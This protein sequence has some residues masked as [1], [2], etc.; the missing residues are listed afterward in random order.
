MAE[1]NLTGLKIKDSYEGL[2]HLNDNGLSTNSGEAAAKKVYD[3]VGKSTCLDIAKDYL[4]I[5]GDGKFESALGDPILT[6]NSAQGGVGIGTDGLVASAALDVRG[7]Y[8]ALDSNNSGVRGWITQGGDAQGIGLAGGGNAG[9]AVADLYVN[10]VGKVGIG[11]ETPGSMLE[12]KGDGVNSFGGI[13]ID[14]VGDGNYGFIDQGVNGT[15]IGLRGASPQDGTQVCE[16]YAK[17]GKVG[18]GTETPQKQLHIVGEM[19]Y[20]HGTPEVGQVLTCTSTTG[21]VA[22]RAPAAGVTASSRF[23]ISTG[24]SPTAII[25]N[26][27][28]FSSIVRIGLGRYRLTFSTPRVS[29]SSYTVVATRE[30]PDANFNG[31]AFEGD[32]VVENRTSTRFELRYTYATFDDAFDNTIGDPPAVNVIVVG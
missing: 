16:L 15:G 27:T 1:E 26:N 6:I 29:A 25:S 24:G 4:K 17:G 2:L 19:R 14:T 9:G 3:G 23:T 22:W 28:G 30:F 21:D 18:I 11:T 20:E 13:A 7:G 8:I 31:E 32:M 12:I 10:Q 5:T